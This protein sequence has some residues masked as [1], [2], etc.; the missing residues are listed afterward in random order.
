MPSVNE[1]LADAAVADLVRLQRY[2][3]HLTRRIVALLNRADADLVRR[4]ADRLESIDR[5]GFDLGPQTTARL[6]RLLKEIRDQSTDLYNLVH[7]ELRDELVQL[8]R[9]EAD[10]QAERID[11]TVGT[12]LN[13]LRPSPETLRSAVT[14]QPFRGK[15]LREWA[16]NL[17]ADKVRRLSDAVRIGIVEGETTDQIVTRIRGTRDAQYR[18][19]I[20]EITRRNAEAITRTAVAHVSN[21]A[22]E[23]L[24]EQNLDLIK[25][26]MWV[27]TIDSRTSAVCRARDRKVYPVGKGPRPPAHVNCRSTVVPVLRSYAELSGDDSLQR[28]RGADDIDTLFRKNL[29][30]QGF[31]EEQIAT[32]QR[33]RRASMDGAIPAELSYSD[34]LRS[35][36]RAFVEDILGKSKAK[37][38]LDGGLSLERFVDRA[39]AEMT[40]AEL[41]KRN[42]SS[43]TRAEVAV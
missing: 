36:P 13:I 41:A 37:L 7:A 11:E 17:E 27:S 40:L 29:R 5:R 39:G 42:R 19:G 6:Q 25:G 8:A 4:I 16:A 1:K 24:F 38:F 30:D 34:W 14:S 9:V 18:D 31:S 2:G 43:F 12:D 33:N 26:V 10:N 28:G 32:I 35:K 20:L 21:R 23:M 22:R 15:L 3:G